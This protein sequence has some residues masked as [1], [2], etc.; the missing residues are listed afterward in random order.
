MLFQNILLL[1]ASLVF[2]AWGE[3]IYIFLM[4]ITI[5]VN[6]FAGICMEKVSAYKAWVL[7]GTIAIDLGLLFYFK[8]F[9]L[10]VITFNKIASAHPLELKD[11]SLI[12]I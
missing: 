1:L 6:F 5:T 2:Y 7:I 3:P 9:N 4:L 8:Y 10:F 11:L 12:H